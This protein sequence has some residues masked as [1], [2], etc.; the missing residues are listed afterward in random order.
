MQ[1]GDNSD[2]ILP[3]QMIDPALPLSAAMEAFKRVKVSQALE[4]V[5]GNQTKAARAR[6]RSAAPEFV[7]AHETAW[8]PLSR[9]MVLHR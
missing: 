7:A 4:A 3:G 6:S 2:P 5:N 9:Q 8:P 1:G